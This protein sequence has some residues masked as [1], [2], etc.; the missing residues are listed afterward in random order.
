M[1]SYYIFDDSKI[2]KQLVEMMQRLMIE[3]GNTLLSIKYKALSRTL[4]VAEHKCF[5]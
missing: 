3:N 5:D 2:I 1:R 4:K